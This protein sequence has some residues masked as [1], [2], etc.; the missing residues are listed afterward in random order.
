MWY[1]HEAQERKPNNHPMNTTLPGRTV[2]RAWAKLAAQYLEERQLDVGLAIDNGWYVSNEAG[3]SDHRI[4]I[5]ATTHKTAHVYWQARAIRSNAYIRYQSPKGPRHEALIVVR[6]YN[7]PDNQG[8]VVVEGAMC[9]LSAA[10]EGYTGYA[11]MGKIPS[12]ATLRHLALLIEDQKD[13]PVVVLLD[14]DSANASVKVA[15]FLSSQGYKTRVGQFTE[16]KDLAELMPAKRRK[17]LE[18][19]FNEFTRQGRRAH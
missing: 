14:R 8:I 2:D 17:L 12:Q 6:P 15:T 19:C 9:A 5:P 3:D 1:S 16:S 10:M 11:L 13:Y 18:G 4:V 7:V